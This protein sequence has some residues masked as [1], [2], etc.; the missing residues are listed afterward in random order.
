MLLTESP[1]ILAHEA[2]DG[3]LSCGGA[4]VERLN[5]WFTGSIVSKAGV[6]E[7]FGYSEL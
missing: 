7:A 1:D 5:G 3:M 2:D 4:A 6:G